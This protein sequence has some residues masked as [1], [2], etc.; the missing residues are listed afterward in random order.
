MRRED[1]DLVLGLYPA[2]VH[3]FERLFG[4]PSNRDNALVSRINHGRQVRKEFAQGN[5]GHSREFTDPGLY[6]GRIDTIHG[7]PGL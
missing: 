5:G 7:L 4:A 6:Q 1:I 2:H 3:I